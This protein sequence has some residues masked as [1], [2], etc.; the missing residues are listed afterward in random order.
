[1]KRWVVVIG[2]VLWSVSARADLAANFYKEGVKQGNDNKIEEAMRNFQ[3]AA[4]LDSKQFLYHL[5]LAYAYEMLNRLPEARAAYDV[6]LA[7]KGDSPE[8]HAGLGNVLRR[9][10]LF[11]LAEKE[12]QK[13][14]SL[15]KKNPD[16]MM[17][18]AV[19][20]AERDDLDKAADMYVK[21]FSVKP[22]DYEAAF[23]AA[24]VFW[25]QKK[26]DDAVK[27]Y[28]K[29][30]DLKPDYIDARFGLG[31]ALKEKGDP[32]GAKPELKKA[33]DGGVKQA[34]KHLFQ[35]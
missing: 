27:Y 18:L 8:G 12:Y 2:M 14:L 32:E 25:R 30:L 5:K 35:M 31:L 13:A 1:M 4:G 28:K 34:C 21:A 26:Y 17:G 6:A 3:K 9:T 33:C 10:K 23:K 16:A 15:N 11:D 19:L 7:L 24:N 29:A 20:F 22:K